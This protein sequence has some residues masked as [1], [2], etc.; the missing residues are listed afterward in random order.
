MLSPSSSRR[1]KS[2]VDD[3]FGACRSVHDFDKLNRLGEG[4]YGVVYRARDRH[5]G[6][7]VALKQVRMEVEKDG[8]PLTSIREIQLL[9]SVK[10]PNIVQLLDV[11]VGAK[12]N[13][14][15][16]VFEYVE[17]DL[18]GLLDNMR[19]PFRPSEVK[20]LLKQLLRAVGHLHENYIIHRDLKMSNLLFANSGELKV[21]DFGLAKKF[22][23]PIR[24]S[25][26][27]IVTLWYRAPEL[28]L[29]D[30]S[31]SM[32]IDM[33]SIGC[34]MGELLLHRPLLPGSTEVEQLRLIINLL[35]TPNEAIW[36][37]YRDLPDAKLISQYFQ[38]Y[39]NLKVKI[40]FL[41]AEGFDLL[42]K[43]LTYD[44][45]KRISAHQALSHHFFSEKPLPKAVDMM[46]TFPTTHERG[47][48]HNKRKHSDD[49]KHQMR[50]N[51][52]HRQVETL[53]LSRRRF[54]I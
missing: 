37:G 33:W 1:K 41:T 27:H 35:G 47:Y 36:P 15:F 29:G 31:Y 5:T 6:D 32:K 21:A 48:R 51:K 10:H 49:V 9:K 45:P 25:T 44:P 30:K 20:C 19:Q 39:N 22:G 50:A 23:V 3:V 24:P 7:I 16:L 14:V 17:H 34:I 28:L 8:I 2:V 12:A 4:T 13:S 18:A 42:N 52:N 54:G 43:F 53:G 38:P 46:P 11:V 26:P 40:P